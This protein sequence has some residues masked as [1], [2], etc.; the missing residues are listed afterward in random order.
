M[1]LKV[2]LTLLLQEIKVPQ[3]KCFFKSFDFPIIRQTPTTAYFLIFQKVEKLW[4]LAIMT[5]FLDAIYI[6][7][8]VESLSISII[9][10]FN[11]VRM[12]CKMCLRNILCS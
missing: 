9:K 7:S 4:H 8:T 5:R 2:Y 12:V 3:L 1:H 11:E 10:W 6:A